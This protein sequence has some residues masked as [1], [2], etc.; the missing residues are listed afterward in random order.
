MMPT[1]KMLSFP[2]FNTLPPAFT[3]N[4]LGFCWWSFLLPRESSV[5]AVLLGRE[6]K[7]D[8]VSVLVTKAL[9]VVVIIVSIVFF[10]EK[11][12]VNQGKNEAKVR[13]K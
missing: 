9:V 7:E 10:G 3:R 2:V 12:E 8:V 13:Q 5:A 6:A 11:N 4:F 1:L